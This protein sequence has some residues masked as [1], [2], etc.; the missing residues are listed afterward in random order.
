MYGFSFDQ[1]EFA[2]VLL[3]YIKAESARGRRLR[4]WMPRLSW[5]IYAFR[6]VTGWKN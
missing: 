4:P 1:Q 2:G 6:R 5:R 3:R